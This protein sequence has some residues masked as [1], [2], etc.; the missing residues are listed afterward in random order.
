MSDWPLKAYDRVIM[1]EADC[2]NLEAAADRLTDAL[3]F[4]EIPRASSLFTDYLYNYDKV[5]RFY[6]D[7]GRSVSPLAE[8][9]RQVGAQEFDRERVADALTKINRRA[10]SP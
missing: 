4:T 9:A 8:H 5:A 7:C 1:S 3:R 10:G 2:R 6:T